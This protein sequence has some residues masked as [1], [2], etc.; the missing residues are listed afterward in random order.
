MKNVPEN[1]LFSAYLD[2]ELTAG[3]QAQVERLLATSPAARQLMEELRA[4]SSTLQTL[5]QYKLEED[6][7]ERVLRL[8]ERRMLAEPAASESRLD[9]PSPRRISWG[10]ILRRVFRP[11]NLL[12]PAV[13]AAVAIFLMITDPGRFPPDDG[14]EV[15]LAPETA[16][17]PAG[18]SPPEAGEKTAEEAAESEES[19]PELLCE[20]RPSDPLAVREGLAGK[21]AAPARPG[22]PEPEHL[23]RHTDSPAIA[24]GS[25][26]P[27]KTPMPEAPTAEP[28]PVPGIGKA[29]G[30]GFGTEG[31]GGAGEELERVTRSV[32]GPGGQAGGVAAR[33]SESARTASAPSGPEGPVPG[34]RPTP[35]APPAVPPGEQQPISHRLVVRCNMSAEAANGRVFDQ[36]LALQRVRRGKADV[37]ASGED[38]RLYSRG[39]PEDQDPAG[40]TEAGP[41]KIAEQIQVDVEATPA[42][43]R[44]IVADLMSRP[45]EF[46]F[47]S[48]LT[49]LGITGARL[50]SLNGRQDMAVDELFGVDQFR[51]TK[52]ARRHGGAEGEDQA[53]QR[54][55]KQGALN[56]AGTVAGYKAERPGA[57]DAAGPSAPSE[58]P[59]EA[60]SR[61]AE[62]GTLRERKLATDLEPSRVFRQPIQP[63]VPS[64]EPTAGDAPEPLE[65]GGAVTEEPGRAPDARGVPVVEGSPQPSPPKPP[66]IQQ[67]EP[68][69]EA[70]EPDEEQPVLSDALVP[71]PQAPGEAQDTSRAQDKRD[72]PGDSPERGEE[73]YLVRFV[74]QVVRPDVPIAGGVMG[75]PPA[76]PAAAMEPEAA[77]EVLEPPAAEAAPA[78]E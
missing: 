29:P 6:L 1:E 77:A 3:E 8:A 50:R 41:K 73:R 28:P 56:S 13:A 35:V 61:G 51:A 26:R 71:E 39:G 53:G 62:M 40:G 10:P 65:G 63:D 21:L 36:V 31:V 11:R 46:S 22:A 24:P 52:A 7:S 66:R 27:P 47:V 54:E 20:V 69:A 68:E 33:D 34:S 18:I 5:P 45:D 16:G 30:P 2:G 19:S 48:D 4:L 32:A 67:E 9:L 14:P 17:E 25:P 12:W 75:R 15:A 60:A 76:S 49:P 38:G 72:A 55:L 23:A 44:A 74:F 43:L 70:D 42:Q 78:R 64:D 59:A 58:S 37:R 57:D